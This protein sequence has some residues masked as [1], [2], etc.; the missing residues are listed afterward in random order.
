MGDPYTG[1]AWP[2]RIDSAEVTVQ[3]DLPVTESL[4]WVTLKKE[5]EIVVP[6][7]A[8]IDWDAQG[9]KFILVGEKFP[10][11]LTAKTKSVVTFP[12]DLFDTVKWHD[13]TPLS[14][15]DFIMPTIVF[16]DRANP[17]SAIYDESSVPYFEAYM[18]YYKG[19]RITSTNPL[20]IE[21]YSDLYYS[22]A[23]LNV[24]TLWPS[25]FYGL[26]GENSWYIQAISNL[27]EENG[28]LA[29]S[30]DKA[31]IEQVEQ[32]SWVGGPSLEILSKY[33]DQSAG[34]SFIPYEAALGQYLTAEEAKAAYENL[35]GW[36]TD[37]GHYWVGTGPYYLDQA[38]LTE[39]TLTLKNNTEFPD[40][41][42]KWASFSQPKLADAQLDG[43]GQ[44]KVGEE[45]VFDVNVTF[46]GEPYARSDIRQ[47]K[48]LLYDATGELLS[49]GEALAVAEGQYQVT[50]GPDVT[51]QLE[52]GS[53]RIEVA[54]VPTPVAVPAFT[55]LDF[56]VVP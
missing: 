13:G 31:D 38:F 43:P 24:A 44:V 7:D 22:D 52:A 41:A 35:Q 10:D 3:S 39:K 34:G 19:F 15:A 46:N 45:A 16:F 23:E 27:A 1:L 21:S 26:S 51:S 33:L 12:A 53:N 42:D 6:P 49:T 25:S 18:S 40:L 14:V 47:V 29:Y 28:E 48:Y 20:T 17:E 36:F 9:Q 32:T 37:H 8:L 54:V 5:D 56:V 50:L 11:G 30:A 55:S 4:G 2:Q